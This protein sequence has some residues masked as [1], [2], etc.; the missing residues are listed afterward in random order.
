MF[1]LKQRKINLLIVKLRIAEAE[2]DSIKEL[3]GSAES[4]PSYYADK[5]IK[6]CGEISAI[7]QQI[8]ILRGASCK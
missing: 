8:D 2:R 4:I 1:F 3:I 7:R 5:Y 6:R